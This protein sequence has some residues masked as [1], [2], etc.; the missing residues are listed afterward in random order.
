[1]KRFNWQFNLLVLVLL[2]GIL[3][4]AAPRVQRILQSD[5]PTE[6]AQVQTVQEQPA[7]AEPTPVYVEIGETPTPFPTVPPPHTPTPVLGPTATAFPLPTAVSD[8]AGSILYMSYNVEPNPGQD[9]VISIYANVVDKEGKPIDKP[10]KIGN[11]VHVTGYAA[12]HPS[13]DGKKSLIDDGWGV[14]YVIDITSGKIESPYHDN[15][16]PRGIFWGWHPDSKHILILAQDNYLDPGLWLVDTDTGQHVTLLA[17]YGT[18]NTL[19]GGAVSPDGQKVVYVLRRDLTASSELWL[20]STNGTEH[21]QIYSQDG[22]IVSL[23]W[24]PDGSHIAFLGD[25]LSILNSD[26][27]DVYPIGKDAV[28][29]LG[30]QPAWSPDSKMLAFVANEQP[31]DTS[32][33][34]ASS[35]DQTDPFAFTNIHIADIVTGESRSLLNDGSTGNIEPAWSP[36]GSQLAFVSRRTGVAEVW[37]VNTDGSNLRML[38]AVGGPTRSPYW[39]AK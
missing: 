30:F 17:L 13:P 10:I 23:V 25:G 4:V 38:T 18:P 34:A 19:I 35:S 31:A 24:S 37:V 36:D 15:P 6:L 11:D 28:V 29:G 8:A 1:M 9:S 22:Y 14:Q 12:I 39:L 5:Q 16:N 21:R 2:A 20:A 27:T 3:Y 7:T 26:G 33:E 32:Q